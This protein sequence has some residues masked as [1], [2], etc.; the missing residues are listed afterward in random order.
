MLAGNPLKI[1]ANEKNA[2]LHTSV[3]TFGN[4]SR[5]PFPRVSFACLKRTKIFRS[6]EGQESFSN[7]YTSIETRLIQ[8]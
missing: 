1:S 5:E 6:G 8:T 3:L 2:F 7:L 4:I